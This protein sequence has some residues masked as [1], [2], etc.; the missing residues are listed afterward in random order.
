MPSVTTWTDLQGT[1][2]REM[3]Q[4]RRKILYD[5]IRTWNLKKKKE[6]TDTQQ[7]GSCQRQAR[8][9]GTE[10]GTELGRR[11]AR[12]K[13]PLQRKPAPGTEHTARSLQPAVL[14]RIR[15]SCWE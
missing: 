2:A 10:L 3:S 8:G 13:L 9:S 7:I 4:K 15:A 11:G 12:S 6:L 5:L 14:W 1:V